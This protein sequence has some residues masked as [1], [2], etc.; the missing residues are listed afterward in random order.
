MD[1]TNNPTTEERLERIERMLAD[2]APTVH[3]LGDVLVEAEHVTKKKDL[4]R[5][6]V[7]NNR[8]VT[9]YQE[10][11]KRK[12]LMSVRDVPVLQNRKRKSK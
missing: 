9:K 7:A 5:N 3:A 8:H 12:L 10:P 1:G 2:L 6:T 11:G 4:H